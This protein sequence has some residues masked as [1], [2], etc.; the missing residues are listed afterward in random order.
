MFS[1]S[2]P[3]LLIFL[4]LFFAIR[5]SQAWSYLSFYLSLL[6]PLLLFFWYA[7]FRLPRTALTICTLLFVFNLLLHVFVFRI[8]YESRGFFLAFE[9]LIPFLFFSRWRRQEAIYLFLIIFG[10]S[11]VFAIWGLLQHF[12]GIGYPEMRFMSRASAYFLVPNTYATWMNLA[13]LPLI[14][15][16]V[17]GVNGLPKPARIAVLPAITLFYAAVVASESRGGYVG[18]AFGLLFILFFLGTS[19]YKANAKRYHHIVLVFFLVVLF[20]KTLGWL[21]LSEWS[22][23]NVL[24]TLSTGDTSFR[25]EIY[26]IAWGLIK[27]NP[28]EGYGYLNF[29]HLFDQHKIPPYLDLGTQFVHSDFLQTWLETGI[30]GFLLLWSIIITGVALLLKHRSRLQQESLPL[31]LMAGAGLTGVFSHAGV[32]FPLY[33]PALVFITSAYLGVVN[34]LAATP[35]SPHTAFATW[36]K[37][38]NSSPRFF[39]GAGIACLVFWISQPLLANYAAQLGLRYLGQGK[40][41]KGAVWHEVARRMQPMDSQYYWKLGIIYRD[42]ATTSNNKKAAQLADD[43]FRQGNEVGP[44]DVTNLLERLR[45]RR[46]HPDL[47]T[48]KVSNETLVAWAKEALTRTPHFS[49]SN[50]EMIR[51]L[52]YVGRRQEAYAMAQTIAQKKPN[53]YSKLLRSFEQRNPDLISR[54]QSTTM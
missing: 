3:P 31:P 15:L 40:S 27:A 17:T 4:G 1:A 13:L 12:F 6:F 7:P 18:L 36:C 24:R 41:Y 35:N 39:A 47:F 46:K 33:I 43:F 14:V 21:G 50:V 11:V 26:T 44:G 29:G 9:Y 45:F 51:T 30:F 48:D 42:Q 53:Y 37:K 49:Q 8:D 28:I 52:E 54:A 34:Q 22:D 16:Y 25:V 23:R 2:I 38:V 19:H 5:A 32:D 20:F 10:I